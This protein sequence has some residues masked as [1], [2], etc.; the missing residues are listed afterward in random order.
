MLSG[1]Y[2]TANAT[3][4]GRLNAY[5]GNQVAQTRDA[6]QLLALKKNFEDQ[7]EN[8]TT[9]KGNKT[10]ERDHQL[11]LA[12]TQAASATAATEVKELDSQ[13]FNLEN[14]LT[15]IKDIL[16]GIEE[17]IVAQNE[18]QSTQ[19]ST[20][21]ELA[22]KKGGQGT[23]GALPKSNQDMMKAKESLEKAYKKLDTLLVNEFIL[24]ETINGVQE[25]MGSATFIS[26]NAN[27]AVALNAYRFNVL[28]G[29]VSCRENHKDYAKN[30]ITPTSNYRSIPLYIFLKKP[31]NTQV[32]DTTISNDLLDNEHGGTVGLKFSGARNTKF[33]FDFSGSNDPA[34]K[35]YGTKLVYDFGIK[36][37][38]VPAVQV[39]GQPVTTNSTYISAGYVGGGLNFEF[40]IF[41][42]TDLNSEFRQTITPGTKPAGGMAIGLG[43]YYNYSDN[44]QYTTSQ[45]SKLISDNYGTIA[46]MYEIHLTERFSL[47]GTRI[48]PAPSFMTPSHQNA[49]TPGSYTSFQ[50][51][52][53]F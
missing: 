2:S 44:K 24:D 34:L 43:V 42:P 35:Q 51:G 25:G 37:I 47:K 23:K 53:K 32:D 41:P 13:I 15:Q 40:P 21:A 45:F 36:L 28:L 16:S 3:L 38:E 27:T 11:K 9:E 48:A 49:D 1:A 19:N 50:L 33:L 52:Y 12:E 22:S 6:A 14:R 46:L 7:E 18:L 20:V 4:L 17:V 30:C 26:S 39:A 5:Y 8:I 29:A 10:T 31:T